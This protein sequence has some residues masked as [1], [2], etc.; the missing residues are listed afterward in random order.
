MGN[1]NQI[2]TREQLELLRVVKSFLQ[3]AMAGYDEVHRGRWHKGI[4]GAMTQ[5]HDTLTNVIDNELYECNKC[6]DC[7][8]PFDPW[9]TC[10]KCGRG[11]ED[12]VR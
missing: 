11:K 5:A 1:P 12:Y 8:T 7:T 2:M 4:A 9:A 6:Y 10:P 3:E